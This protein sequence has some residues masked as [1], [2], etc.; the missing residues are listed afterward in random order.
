MYRPKE[1]GEVSYCV[2]KDEDLYA[3]LYIKFFYNDVTDV[4]I[5]SVILHKFLL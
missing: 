1:K 4:V 2:T 5:H 3:N